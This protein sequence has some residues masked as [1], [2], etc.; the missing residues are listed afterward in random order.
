[1]NEDLRRRFGELADVI[2]ADVA[3]HLTAV[4]DELTALVEQERAAAQAAD[5]ARLAAEQQAAVRLAEASDAAATRGRDEGRH[6]GLAQGRA[7]WADAH[8][9][10]LA[11]NERLVEAIRDI[12]RAR[13]LSE[14]LDT[15]ARCAGRQAARVAIL[16]AHGE[17][18]HSWRLVGFGSA[19]DETQELEV[20][21]ADAGVVA[22]AVRTG[23]PTSARNGAGL[24]APAFTELLAGRDM[25]AVP[26]SMGGHVAAVLYADEGP[27]AP[28]GASSEEQP[29]AFWP[30]A[31]EI[32]ARHATRCLE[33]MTALR[34]AQVL[35]ERPVGGTSGMDRA[36]LGGPG[37]DANNR[38]ED[39]DQAA[40]RYA[41]LLVS[42]I[43]LYHEPAVVAG[44]R[45]R[46]LTTRLGG[47][48]ARARVLY[49]QR[50]P[51]HVR[52]AT[53]HFQEE[54]VRT[55]ADGDRTLFGHPQPIPRT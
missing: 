21:I 9:N 31:L 38:R 2:R 29:R 14:I 37:R 47:E 16:L 51:A 46:D 7:A 49:E 48:I 24:V 32:M 10:G 26:V 17:K 43:K 39:E 40:R 53:D 44:R 23:T 42:E 20:P 19:L 55:L 50:V 41:R 36:T 27:A 52:R 6:E 45:E 22:D 8:A 13:S 34:T 1:M 30:M 3:R 5:D 11:A 33:T 54:L 15:L 18:L 28:G 25:L 4:A 35:V 12:D